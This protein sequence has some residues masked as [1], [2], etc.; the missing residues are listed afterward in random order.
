MAIPWFLCGFLL[1]ISVL[2]VLKLYLIKK[3]FVV[4]KLFCNTTT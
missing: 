4:V 1:C 3:D 2:L